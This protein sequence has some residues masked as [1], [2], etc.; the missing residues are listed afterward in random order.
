MDNQV[1]TLLERLLN[2]SDLGLA[3]TPAL[4]DI[5]RFALGRSP[6][7]TDLTA[8]FG[9]QRIE[10]RNDG[11]QPEDAPQELVQTRKDS[12]L[13]DFLDRHADVTFSF[14]RASI[15]I[16]VPKDFEGANTVRE[17]IQAAKALEERP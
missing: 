10:L 7:E 2:P 4:R 15:E 13:L 16:D 6:V 12:E 14:E 1:T 5:V 11:S 17:V 9:T 3:T 8:Y